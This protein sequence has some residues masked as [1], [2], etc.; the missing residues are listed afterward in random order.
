MTISTLHV[1]HEKRQPTH[2]LTH[3]HTLYFLS[4]CLSLCWF[5]SLLF[6]EKGTAARERARAHTH[7]CTH[8]RVHSTCLYP[9]EHRTWGGHSCW[10]CRSTK[11]PP[12]W[13]ALVVYV[14][15]YSSV[16]AEIPILYAHTVH[17]CCT[18]RVYDHTMHSERNPQTFAVRLDPKTQTLSLYSN[19]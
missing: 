15:R 17:T 18:V 9:R 10:A 6:E 19:G 3:A 1:R 8:R 13:L 2:T 11:P 14:L 4:L 16:S 7:T 5:S 12:P